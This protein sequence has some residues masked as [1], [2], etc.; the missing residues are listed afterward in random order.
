VFE[1]YYGSTIT[2]TRFLTYSTSK[3]PWPWK[4]V[5]GSVD[6]TVR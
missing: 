6:I 3:M 1:S 2:V 5:Y 4:P